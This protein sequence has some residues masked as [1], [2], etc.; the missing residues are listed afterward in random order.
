M[1]HSTA[2][3]NELNAAKRLILKH[4]ELVIGSLMHISGLTQQA[5]LGLYRTCLWHVDRRLSA[6]FSAVFDEIL[7]RCKEKKC[8][9]TVRN[10]SISV[11]NALIE[12]TK[13]PQSNLT[14]SKKSA[15]ISDFFC[16]NLREIYFPIEP[17]SHK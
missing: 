6:S 8:V 5:I 13:I 4:F 3:V 9:F 15:V 1:R 14:F 7:F 11:A 16:G 17:N 12:C 10:R 2:T